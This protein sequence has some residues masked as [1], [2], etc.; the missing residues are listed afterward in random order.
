MKK[1]VSIIS[2]LVLFTA[3]SLLSSCNKMS[4]STGTLIV[5][6]TNLKYDSEVRVFPYAVTDNS[7]PIAIKQI[8]KGQSRTVTFKLDAGNYL[9]DCTGADVIGGDGSAAIQIQAG[10]EHNLY[11][12]GE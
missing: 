1:L 11:F 3:I 8:N 2:I 7:D 10:Q 6:I 5:H 9:V 4:I 12:S